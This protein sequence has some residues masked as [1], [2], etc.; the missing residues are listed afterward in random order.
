MKRSRHRKAEAAAD[1]D[2]RRHTNASPCRSLGQ[3]TEQWVWSKAAA[4]VVVVLV[5]YLPAVPGDF[6]WDDDAYVSQNAVLTGENGLWR[7]WTELGATPQYYPLV[8]TTFWI[9]YRL[10]GLEP[11]GYHLVNILLHGLSAVVL[12]R[13]LS[14]LRIPAAWFAAAVFGSRN[15]KTR[16][17]RFSTC[18]PLAPTCIGVRPAART[19]RL[20]GK[21]G[22]MSCR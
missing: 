10:W 3:S 21:P 4:L 1:D 2:S 18:S 7:I 8:F 6:I 16:Y 11:Q 13:I 19:R 14:Y 9:E 17:P 22:C 12:W 5:A 15:E 20:G